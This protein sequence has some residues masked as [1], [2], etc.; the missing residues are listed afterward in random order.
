MAEAVVGLLVMNYGT[1][2]NLDEVEPYYTHIR[3]GRKATPELLEELVGRYQ[4]IGKSPLAEISHAQA[5]GVVQRLGAGFKLYEGNKH[6]TPFIQEAV[7]NMAADGVR[8]GVGLVLAPHYSVMSIGSYISKAEEAAAP[9]GVQLTYVKHWHMH[10]QFIDLLASRVNEALGLFPAGEP[11]EVIFTAHSLP[12]R[13]LQMGDPYVDQLHESGHAVAKQL[14]LTDYSFGWQSA[15]RTPEPWFGPDITETLKQKAA[16]G[17]RHV[18]VCPQ[19]FVADHLEVLYDLD[20]EGKKLAE[21]LGI[22]FARTRSLNDD[23]AFLDCL[24]TVVREH[25]AEVG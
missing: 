13:I 22:G 7:D 10:P 6:I 16:V 20:I 24:A 11:V 1:P 9:L 23:P 5:V 8:R 4:A 18:L 21:E 15:G 14:G 2:R 3:G 12:Q 25:L 17:V 19:G